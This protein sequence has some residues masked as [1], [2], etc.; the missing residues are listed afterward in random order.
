[1]S[2]YCR[3]LK[4]LLIS[5]H[6]HISSMSEVDTADHITCKYLMYPYGSKLIRL[7]LVHIH[8]KEKNEIQTDALVD[9]GATATVVPNELADLIGLLP[10]GDEAQEK[11]KKGEATGA[12]AAFPT[13]IL[14]LAELR[15]IKGSHVFDTLR[16]IDVHVPRTSNIKIPYVVLGRN[17][18]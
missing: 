11:A 18:L 7:P 14:R 13:Y 1:M 6:I 9:S 10:E 17:Y 12:S 15:V 2:C 5:P 16:E 4:I 3:T 8:L